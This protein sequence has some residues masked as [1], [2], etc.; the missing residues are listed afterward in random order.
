MMVQIKLIFVCI[1]KRA[2]KDGK[3]STCNISFLNYKLSCNNL[4][5]CDLKIQIIR[6]LYIPLKPYKKVSLLISKS[7]ISAASINCSKN[8]F[9]IRGVFFQIAKRQNCA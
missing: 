7:S 2:T 9:S 5:Y 4:K 8:A 6:H 1:P 3:I